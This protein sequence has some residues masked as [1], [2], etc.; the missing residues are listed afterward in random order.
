MG[1]L[2]QGDQFSRNETIPKE[3][4]KKKT[5]IKPHRYYPER[6]IDCIIETKIE[7]YK[8]GKSENKKEPMEFKNRRVVKRVFSF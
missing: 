2:G 6:E 5:L 4:K 7:C 1:Q 8:R 3:K